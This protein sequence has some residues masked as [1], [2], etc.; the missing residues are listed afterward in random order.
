MPYQAAKL[1]SILVREVRAVAQLGERSL[2][3]I[4]PIHHDAPVAGLEPVLDERVGNVR[5]VLGLHFGNVYRDRRH[6]ESIF[7]AYPLPLTD[8]G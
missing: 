2:R 1:V 5:Q 6:V 8:T 4:E 3:G 7:K